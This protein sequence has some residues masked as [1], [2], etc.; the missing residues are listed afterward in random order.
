MPCSYYNI[1]ILKRADGSSAVASAAYQSGERLFEERTNHQVSYEN[2]EG[3]LYTEILLPENAP[4]KFHD[5]NTLWNSVEQT[6]KQYNS[7]LARKIIAALPK[8]IPLDDQIRL[9]RE[10][11]QENFS[12][13]GMCVDLAIHDN[14]DGN[15]HAHILL[16]LRALDENG[17]WL[18]KSRKVYD[19]DEN[20]ERIR[21]PSGYYASHK[22]KTT[23]WDEQSNAEKWRHSW[24]EINNRYLEKNG[25]QERLDMRS[26]ERQGADRIP[27]I[28]MGPQVYQ[29][30]KRGIR[31]FIGDINRGIQSMND[32]LQKIHEAIERLKERAAVLK[33]YLQGIMASIRNHVSEYPRPI[34]IEDLLYQ[35]LRDQQ[36]ESHQ[37]PKDYDEVMRLMKYMK[38][39]RIKFVAD[40]YSELDQA[41]YRAGQIRSDL[42]SIQER[43]NEIESCFHHRDTVNKHRDVYRQYQKQ[44][45]K[46]ARQTFYRTHKKEIDAYRKS[47]RILKDL[48]S[49]SPENVIPWKDMKN[50]HTRLSSERNR[51]NAELSEIKTLTNELSAVLNYTDKVRQK[52]PLK[53]REEPAL[54][55]QLEYENT[56]IPRNDYER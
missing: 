14:G 33:N 41:D 54:S 46:N 4:E 37:V 43:I 50:E 56:I 42:R 6:E 10:Y 26:Y 16:T 55:Y 44:F 52:H 38:E 40:I 31:T 12:G 23:D 48:R 29:M 21:L 30:E 49:R 47:D 11:C 1:C 7:Q 45:F 28:H 8:E 5:R 19:L 24:E 3:V 22:A 34:T 18:P 27:Q 20:G 9:L 2:K 25:V 32:Q 36:E 35:Y 53:D 51:R 17:K 13:K 15:P 39:H